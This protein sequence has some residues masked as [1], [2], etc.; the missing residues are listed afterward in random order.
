MLFTLSHNRVRPRQLLHLLAVITPNALL[1]IFP[2][3]KKLT[4]SFEVYP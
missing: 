2:S 3:V 4:S 1:E